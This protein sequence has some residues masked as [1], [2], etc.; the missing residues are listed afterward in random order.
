MISV[1]DREGFPV[2][3]LWQKHPRA[4]I[5]GKGEKN[6]F[7]RTISS[8]YPNT[9]VMMVT[10]MEY[11][12]CGTGLISLFGWAMIC[13]L[14]EMEPGTSPVFYFHACCAQNLR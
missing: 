6:V 1:P 14:Q 4:G 9:I 8:V 13:P 2:L 10:M 7:H 11:V 12:P 3:F 5:R